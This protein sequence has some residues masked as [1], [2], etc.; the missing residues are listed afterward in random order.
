MN[1][2]GP[3]SA[4]KIQTGPYRFWPIGFERHWPVDTGQRRIQ[5]FAPTTRCEEE[6]RWFGRA[7]KH[8]ADAAGRGLDLPGDPLEER[9]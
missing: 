3:V 4:S 7:P 9:T 6:L 1:T 2:S 5:S 8:R